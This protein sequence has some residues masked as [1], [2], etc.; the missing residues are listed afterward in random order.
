MNSPYVPSTIK[1]HF[2]RILALD[3]IRGLAILIVTVYRFTKEAFPAS[4]VGNAAANVIE[5]GSLGVDLFFV[6]S[7]FLIT[8][9]LLQ[10]KGT[11]NYFSRFYFRRSLR[12]F[13][14]YFLTLT[15]LLIFLPIVSGSSDL[16]SEATKHQAFLWTYTSNLKMAW[17][18][19][20]CFGYLDHFW[21]LAVEEQFYLVWPLVIF[22]ASTRL[23]KI[24]LFGVVICAFAR[25]LFCAL[26]ENGVA[27]DVF[28]LFRCDGLLLGAAVALL[29]AQDPKLT[30]I[31]R[32]LPMIFALAFTL[33]ATAFLLGRSF[34]GSR[35]LLVATCWTSFFVMV[36]LS[37][38]GKLKRCMELGFL[39]TLGK[40]SYG[41]YVFQSPLIPIL[42]PLFAPSGF[43]E[44][45]SQS[46]M[47]RV[48]YVLAMSII[49]FLAAFVSWHAFESL[50]L[51]LRDSKPTFRS[52][53]VRPTLS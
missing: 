13:P 38:K 31:S 41:M 32:Y 45:I 39:R 44:P 27:P 30:P 7:G 42:R 43:G 4:F 18:N 5:A 51:R 33:M 22:F 20:W 24:T 9:I 3:G 11:D 49:T 10:A 47:E 29:W 19:Q 17:E 40:Y 1:P 12:I 52:R 26:S 36:L 14:L 50:I 35:Q 53:Q 28:I 46:V 15:G 23:L 6:L 48:G 21:S 25:A 34:W 37:E 16:F 8:G 2:G